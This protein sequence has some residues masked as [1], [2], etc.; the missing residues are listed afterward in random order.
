M[1]LAL[2]VAVDFGRDIRPLLADSCF[3]CHGPDS[4]TRE[5][6]LRLDTRDGAFG[7]RGGYAAFVPGDVDGSEAMLRILSEEPDDRMPPPDSNLTLTGGEK[8][9]IAEWVR[10]GA[11]WQEHW[12]FAPPEELGAELDYSLLRGR[13]PI[14]RFVADRLETG[15]S[16]R[17][18]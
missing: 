11:N 1:K 10:S 9:L 6:D 15:E 12:A 3:P 17:L 4:E 8:Q 5:A 18:G 13:N 16:R 2:P 7:D 14:D